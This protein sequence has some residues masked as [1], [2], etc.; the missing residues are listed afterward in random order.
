L[1][2]SDI[3]K[4]RPEYVDYIKRTNAFFP[5]PRKRSQK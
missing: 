5:G 4:R 1:L 2:E 3:A